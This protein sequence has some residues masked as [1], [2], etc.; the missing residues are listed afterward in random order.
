MASRSSFFRLSRALALLA[1]ATTLACSSSDANQ[2][3][4]ACTPD[5]ADGI[6]D[7]PSPLLVVVTDSEFKPKILTTQ[8]SSEITL[9]LD[10]QGTTPHS[11]VVDCLPTP[12]SD[13]CPMQSCFPSEAKV[14][15]VL[16]GEQATVVFESPLVEGI[17][18]FHSDVPEDTELGSGQFIIQ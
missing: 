10:N 18:V 6:I 1:A 12:N 16:P 9:T 17:Y 5:D 13:G 8:N 7:E 2:S 3:G 11:F 14:E 4:D 15:P